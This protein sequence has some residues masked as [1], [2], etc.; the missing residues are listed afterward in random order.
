M[1]VPNSQEQKGTPSPAA[2]PNPLGEP[3]TPPLSSLITSRILGPGRT[4]TRLF[5]FALHLG[6]SGPWVF[7]TCGASGRRGPTQTQCDGAYAGSSVQ[8]TVGAAGPLKGVQLW[9]VP[10]TGEYL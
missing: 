3:Q 9:R 1:P 4:G 5:P 10:A 2:L 8:V 7:T 6:T